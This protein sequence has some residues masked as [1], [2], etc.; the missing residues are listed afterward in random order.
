[1]FCCLQGPEKMQD[2]YIDDNLKKKKTLS[3][4]IYTKTSY[5]LGIIWLTVIL[6]NRFGAHGQ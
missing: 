6:V 5:D 3:K 4:E 1:M 2:E